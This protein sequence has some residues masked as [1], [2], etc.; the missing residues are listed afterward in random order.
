VL[1]ELARKESVPVVEMERLVREAGLPRNQAFLDVYHPTAGVHRLLAEELARVLRPRI[2]AS[3]GSA[4]I[5]SPA[6]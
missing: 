1:T 5:A 3:A 2:P 6:P 4:R